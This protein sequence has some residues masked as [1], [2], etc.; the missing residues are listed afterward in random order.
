MRRP[1]HAVL[2]RGPGIVRH[3]EFAPGI[4]RSAT[5]RS[6]PAPAFA[7]AWAGDQSL[8]SG[9]RSTTRGCCTA[10]GKRRR[11]QFISILISLVIFFQLAISLASQAFASSGDLLGV[12][13]I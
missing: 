13:S 2:L 1:Q 9:V 5:V 8:S 10:S 6:A 3:S 12:A 4:A 11:V 7:D